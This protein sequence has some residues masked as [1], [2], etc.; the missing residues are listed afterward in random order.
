MGGWWSGGWGRRV[1]EVEGRVAGVE[2]SE[3]PEANLR[4]CDRKQ[5]GK[6]FTEQHSAGRLATCRA[7]AL[8]L[9]QGGGKARGAHLALPWAILLSPFGADDF[10]GETQKSTARMNKR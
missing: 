10:E 3:P 9:T 8:R 4:N 6:S 7:R 2:R 5:A 1:A